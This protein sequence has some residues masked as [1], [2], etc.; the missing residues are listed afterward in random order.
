MRGRPG[1]LRHLRRR[2]RRGRAVARPSSGT[3]FLRSTSVPT[4]PL[5]D[6]KRSDIDSRSSS[7]RSRKRESRSDPPS[8]TASTT[9]A[10]SSSQRVSS[11]G[12]P[13]ESSRS[14]D[15]LRAQPGPDLSLRRRRLRLVDAAADEV[16]Q[17]RRELVRSCL[18]ALAEQRGDERGLGV[19]R[20]LLLVLAVVAGAT[21]APHEPEDGGDDEQRGQRPRARAR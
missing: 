7:I 4:A 20:R 2:A 16:E 8:S 11:C 14:D 18:A 13:A 15:V 6:S 12:S 10:T 21:L 5:N 9:P 19:G 1:A 17:R 3:S